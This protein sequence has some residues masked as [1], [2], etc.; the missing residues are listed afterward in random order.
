[1]EGDEGII[2]IALDTHKFEDAAGPREGHIVDGGY[3]VAA[4]DAKDRL[5]EGEDGWLEADLDGGLVAG[6]DGIAAG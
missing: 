4:V 6:G 2:A 3:A 1:M 5:M